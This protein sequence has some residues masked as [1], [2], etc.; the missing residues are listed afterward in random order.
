MLCGLFFATI[1]LSGAAGLTIDRANQEL[2]TTPGGRL[3]VDVDFGS[4][5]VKAG[6]E[7]RV[8]LAAE[9]KLDFNDEQRE[10]DYAAAAPITI[11]HEGNVVTVRAHGE[12]TGRRWPWHGRTSVDAT[13]TVTVPKSFDADLRTGS[14]CIA[15][16]G[17]IG[18]VKAETSGGK[19]MFEELRGALNGNTSGGSVEVKRCTGPL[20][21]STSGG[22][23]AAAGGSGRIDAR[24]SGG[25]IA[26]QDFSGDTNV[27][28]SGGRL[29]LLNINGSII[30]RTSGGSVRATLAAP[31]PGDVR[32][33]TSAGSIEVAIPT[34][35]ALQID[36]VASAGRV[37]TELPISGERTDRESLRGTLNGGGRSLRL[38]S[39]AGSI[40]ILAA[41]SRTS[42]DETSS[43]Q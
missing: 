5:E 8:R 42:A 38:R 35:A 7:N 41:D 18:T 6:T 43:A 39:G 26:V 20:T 23:I 12:S 15:A 9:R 21:V 40:R 22:A 16:S 28:T 4:V 31:V 1:A 29:T 30:G 14:G 19:L 3:V 11:T 13:Y 25:S 36:A 24:T 34:S 27:E 2:D 37:S 10:R 17:L 32:L 33:E